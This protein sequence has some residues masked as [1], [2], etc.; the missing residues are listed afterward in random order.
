MQ[1][2]ASCLFRLLLLLNLNPQYWHLYGLAPVWIRLCLLRLLLVVKSLLHSWHLKRRFGSLGVVEG[3]GERFPGC[4]V[5]LCLCFSFFL[6]CL[7][8]LCCCLAY[9]TARR[10]VLS[11][12]GSGSPEPRRDEGDGMDTDA[13]CFRFSALLSGGVLG[14]MSCCCITGG[15]RCGCCGCWCCMA[16]RWWACA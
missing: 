2:T 13:L 15:D 16:R 11:P 10:M 3:G 12:S 9:A 7:A 6:C 4:E 1:Y 8:C 14:E 5:R